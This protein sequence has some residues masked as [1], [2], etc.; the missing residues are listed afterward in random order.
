MSGL[1]ANLSNESNTNEITTITL[2][3]EARAALLQIQERREAQQVINDEEERQILEEHQREVRRMHAF[4]SGSRSGNNWGNQRT[5]EEERQNFESYQ[6]EANRIRQQEN[7]EAHTSRGSRSANNQLRS[8]EAAAADY[9]RNFRYE[10]QLRRQEEARQ[11]REQAVNPQGTHNAA[12]PIPP[13]TIPKGRRPYHEPQGGPERHYLGPMNVE[14]NHC[15]AFHFDSEKLSNSTRANK[16]FGSCCLQGQIQ[17][18]AFREPPRSLKEMLC[19][20]SPHSESFKKKHLAIQ[21][22]ICI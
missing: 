12:N 2:W 5:L 7:L 4:S 17:L 8:E 10:N 3:R 15:H 11:Q 22:C 13:Q 6:R 20:I 1:L 18:P 21:C 9:E 19:G 16:K 14:C